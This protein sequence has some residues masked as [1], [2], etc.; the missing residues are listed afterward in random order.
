VY[1]LKVRIR[2]VTITITIGY[3]I[4][5][6]Y[7]ESVLQVLVE[8]S[9]KW[10]SGD[11]VILTTRCPCRDNLIFGCRCKRISRRELFSLIVQ[12]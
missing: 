7:S 10:K 5:Y 4:K 3:K 8:L 12:K 9:Y 1:R 6:K 2:R 11:P